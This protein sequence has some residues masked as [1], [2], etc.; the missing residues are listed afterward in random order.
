M[1]SVQRTVLEINRPVQGKKT[2]P[3]PEVDFFECGGVKYLDIPVNMREHLEGISR[4]DLY[5][6]W[7]QANN[8]KV[9]GNDDDG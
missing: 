2:M 9:N 1:A 6:L 8:D 3:L 5:R 4:S 7:E